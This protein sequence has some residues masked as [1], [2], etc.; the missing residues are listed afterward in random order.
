[1]VLEYELIY[2]NRMADNIQNLSNKINILQSHRCFGNRLNQHIINAL[3]N[4]FDTKSDKRIIDYIN[5][6]RKIR[7]LNTT[8]I[9]IDSFLYGENTKNPNLMILVK[10]NGI[11]FIHL[12]IHLC[13]KGLNPKGSGIIHF[14]KDVYNINKTNKSFDR[15]DFYS[16][17]FVKVPENKPN[18]LVF[19]IKDNKSAPLYAKHENIQQIKK[20]FDVV[21]DVLNK[22]FDEYNQ[23]YYVGNYNKVSY[24]QPL[25]PIHNK[26]NT[27]LKNINLFTK[28]SIRTNKGSRMGP[29][30][31]TEQAL[32]HKRNRKKS[33]RA[34]REERFKKSSKLTR[35]SNRAQP[36]KNPYTNT[37]NLSPNNINEMDS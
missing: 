10:K 1:M 36:N 6:E 3:I 19:S 22:L 16:I 18:S 28:Y 35:K 7:G 33:F 12:T 4:L 13:I 2:I 30:E 14:F 34:I 9:S 29:V 11:D 21:I 25:Y 27:V 37:Y 8:D 24:I 15:K 17:I 20:E 32:N 23:E 26:T 5:A 31:S